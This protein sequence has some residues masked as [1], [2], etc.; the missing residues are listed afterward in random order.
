MPEEH[1]D[2]AGAAIERVVVRAGDV[3]EIV[4]DPAACHAFEHAVIALWK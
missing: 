1:L 4:V 2:R 3:L